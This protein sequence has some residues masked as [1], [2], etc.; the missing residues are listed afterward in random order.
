MSKPPKSQRATLRVGRVSKD[1]SAA[2]RALKSFE[3]SLDLDC[4]MTKEGDGAM[5]ASAFQLVLI[6]GGTPIARQLCLYDEL[7]I[8]RSPGCGLILDDPGVSRLHARI[9]GGTVLDEE[10]ANGTRVNGTPISSHELR[11]GDVIQVGSH[12]LVFHRAEGGVP[13]EAILAPERPESDVGHISLG[14]MTLRLGGKT[15]TKPKTAVAVEVPRRGYLF[16]AGDTS[17]LKRKALQMAVTRDEFVIGSAEGA[18]LP[19]QGF[20]T[21]R[22]VAIIV[23]GLAGFSLV[24][25]PRWP[26][27]VELCGTLIT[28]ATSL[29]DGDKIGISGLELTFRHGSS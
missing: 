24:P 22:V 16:L 1:V 25:F 3:S 17:K 13:A 12:E 15:K 7:A 8:G 26:L 18:D 29:E 9:S 14:D 5:A 19:L 20:R 11:D 4:W 2:A 6:K 27:K 23:R 10:S 21:P 28:T